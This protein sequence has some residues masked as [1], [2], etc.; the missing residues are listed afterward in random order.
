M[1]Q[2]GAGI[3]TSSPGSSRVANASKTAC[4]PP[5]VTTTWAAS[6]EKPVSRPVFAAIASLSSGSPG[7]GVYRWFFGSR[8]ASTAASTICAGVGKSG[9][10]APKPT[11]SSPAAFRALA[12]PSMARVADSA[13]AAMR[14]EMRPLEA[15]SAETP[16]PGY[17]SSGAIGPW[18]RVQCGARTP[19]KATAEAVMAT[20]AR[21]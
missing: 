20:A 17:P 8:Q 16:S 2:Y 15:P 7:A 12:L 19:Y 6:T 4:L 11:T 21:P 14:A 18:S 5:L 3:S 9:S 10:P 13:T 1:V